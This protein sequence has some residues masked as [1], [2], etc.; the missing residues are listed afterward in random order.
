M[1]QAISRQARCAVARGVDLLGEKW[2][3]MIT[4]EAFWGRTRFSDFRK[5]LGVAPDVLANRLAALVHEGVLE[6]RTY[7]V[8]G[9]RAREEYVLTPAGLDLVFVL[10]GLARW[11]QEHRPVDAG[12]APVYTDAETG[13]AVELCFVT[14]DGRRVEPGQLAVRTG[15]PA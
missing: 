5:N 1:T 12:T 10:A 13:E 3:L 4:R 14:K 15:E 9:A 8:T 6:R 11:G 7:Q 2:V